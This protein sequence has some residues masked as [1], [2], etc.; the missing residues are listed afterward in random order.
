MY[1]KLG[2]GA[3]T[4]GGRAIRWP[5]PEV[6]S[7]RVDGGLTDGAT[8]KTMYG[9]DSWSRNIPQQECGTKKSRCM[10]LDVDG[11]SHGCELFL[12]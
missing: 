6:R 7:Y 10:K 12:V 8:A 2:G 1:W 5:K 9:F 4:E 3:A 11:E